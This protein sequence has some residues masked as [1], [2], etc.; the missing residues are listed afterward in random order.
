MF[1]KIWYLLVFCLFFGGLSYWNRDAVSSVSYWATVHNPLYV[2]IKFDNI[3]TADNPDYIVTWNLFSLATFSVVDGWCNITKYDNNIKVTYYLPDDKLKYLQ[4]NRQTANASPAHTCKISLFI[5]KDDI[6]DYV[7]SHLSNISSGEK[8]KLLD[9]I[10]YGL[11]DELTVVLKLTTDSNGNSLPDYTAPFQAYT[12]IYKYNYSK[13]ECSDGIDNDGDG[14]ID[15]PHDPGCSSGGDLTENKSVG[16]SSKQPVNKPECSDGIDNDGDG[17]IDYPH[18][19]G[20]VSSNDVSETDIK[21]QNVHYIP[22]IGSFNS[23]SNDYI[24]IDSDSVQKKIVMLADYDDYVWNLLPIGTVEV[25]HDWTSGAKVKK[26]IMTVMNKDG[27]SPI[28]N[29]CIYEG[30]FSNP[31]W[32]WSYIPLY[33]NKNCEVIKNHLIGDYMISFQYVDT[34]GYASNQYN[35]EFKIIPWQIDADKTEVQFIPLE[36]KVYA[37]AY[38]KY[39]YIVTFKDKYGH[40]VFDTWLVNKLSLKSNDPIYL[41]EIDNSWDAFYSK[42]VTNASLNNS[43]YSWQIYLFI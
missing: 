15:Y 20:C 36:N 18:D 16:G 39:K 33:I 3:K 34:A 5:D 43:K 27:T 37:D 28:S 19:P 10:S 35:F 31:K 32:Q 9:S 1:K 24:S 38:S 25:I 17:L 41:N 12:L 11:Y 13:P 26:I 23:I 40:Y 29:N 8:E 30:S 2:T 14:L 22:Q 7:D 42:F 6:K 4:Q 21:I